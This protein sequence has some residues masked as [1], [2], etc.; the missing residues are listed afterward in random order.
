[1]QQ[2]WLLRFKTRL[3][4]LVGLLLGF[5]EL[6]AVH[7]GLH[8]EFLQPAD[9]FFI[10]LKD[11]LLGHV[12]QYR[13]S[14]IGLFQQSLCHHVVVGIAPE[15]DESQQHL[16]LL[17]GT[18]GQLVHQLVDF[19]FVSVFHRQP[20]KTLV[21]GLVFLVQFLL[22]HEDALLHHGMHQ[23]HHF[24]ETNDLAHLADGDFR[25]DLQGFHDEVFE[26]VQGHG[27]EHIV[28]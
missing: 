22:H 16:Q 13:G 8:L 7:I 11:A 14:G 12:F 25:L 5:G 6:Y 4:A 19:G 27:V 21:F 15:G 28:G 18:F 9:L 17:V 24:L 10:N 26:V 1:M 20:H 23:R 3:N 2:D